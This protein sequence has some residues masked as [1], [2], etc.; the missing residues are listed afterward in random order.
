MRK[1][2]TFW[3]ITVFDPFP[4]FEEWIL[5][6]LWFSIKKPI[7]G[8]WLKFWFQNAHKWEQ[9]SITEAHMPKYC[10][11]W[12]KTKQNWSYLTIFR[13]YQPKN[14]RFY[15][16]WPKIVIFWQNR[17]TTNTTKI[18]PYEK[19]I[20]KKSSDSSNNKGV[21]IIFKVVHVL[22]LHPVHILQNRFTGKSL[23]HIEKI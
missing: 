21:K 5:I 3:K 20:Y 10:Q 6:C 15:R 23:G 17:K 8:Q 2:E 22:F 1:K 16:L 14:R 12:V 9:K 11:N 13:Y 18:S 19:S 7:F 4:T